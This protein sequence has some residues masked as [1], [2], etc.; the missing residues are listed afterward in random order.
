MTTLRSLSRFYLDLICNSINYKLLLWRTE[1]IIAA[2]CRYFQYLHNVDE[3]RFSIFFSKRV[4]NL[5]AVLQRAM[6]AVHRQANMEP[7]HLVV[8]H[9]PVMYHRQLVTTHHREEQQEDLHPLHP[10][11]VHRGDMEVRRHQVDMVPQHL[12]LMVRLLEGATPVDT[13]HPL[14]NPHQG[15]AL[16]CGSGFRLVFALLKYLLSK[17]REV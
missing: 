12:V 11:M 5:T 8:T 13:E 3:V 6:E 9:P 7:L 2:H 1:Y 17:M 4:N 14:H 15:S 16:I 10:V